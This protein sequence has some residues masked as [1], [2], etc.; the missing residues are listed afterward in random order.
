MK[1]HHPERIRACRVCGVEMT[2][3]VLSSHQRL[4]HT[5]E[6]PAYEKFYRIVKALGFDARY[7]TVEEV[8]RAG[9][10]TRARAR[11]MLQR[12]TARGVVAEAGP[13]GAGRPLWYVP[14]RMKAR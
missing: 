9:G 2:R 4:Y 1:A 6:D 3:Q 8:A 5:D 12:L 13:E 14:G 11:E 10:V 7:F